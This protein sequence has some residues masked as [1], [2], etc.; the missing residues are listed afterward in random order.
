MM[1]AK[2]HLI[3]RR[4]SL[5]ALAAL[6]LISLLPLHAAEPTALNAASYGAAGEVS[7]SLHLLDTGN[8]R[9]LIDCG[10]ELETKNA[11]SNLAQSLPAGIESVNAVFLTHAHV[12]HLGRL[13]LLVERGFAGPI[14]A[15]PATAA[16]AVP[17]L[18]A[19]ISCNRSQ[20]RHWTW[21]KDRLTRSEATRKPLWVHWR[22]CKY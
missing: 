12:D 14:Y 8:G 2:S 18:R 5:L 7:G 20:P 10:A 11:G 9:W 19:E 21:S 13:P 1:F 16:L 22:G 6:W 15:S 17:M 3:H 4:P